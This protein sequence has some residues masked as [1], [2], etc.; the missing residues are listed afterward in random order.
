MANETNM[1]KVQL[2]L[3]ALERLIGGDSEMEVQLRHQVVREFSKHH[4]T[5]LLKD[6]TWKAAD[7][8]LRE[9]IA[10]QVVEVLGLNLREQGWVPAYPSQLKNNI[11]QQIRDTC[12]QAVREAIS[13]AIEERVEF[14]KNGLIAEITR[15]INQ[16]V[17]TEVIKGI[18]AELEAK[19]K[20]VLG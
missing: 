19:L 16:V 9:E 1:V 10:K 11:K 5:A 15:Q 17:R 13:K 8:A 2:N 18:R 3:P 14:L 7:K 6:E 12:E 4:L 20:T